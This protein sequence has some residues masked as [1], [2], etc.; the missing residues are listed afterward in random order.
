MPPPLS[1]QRNGVI[2]E[3]LVGQYVKRRRDKLALAL[4]TDGHAYSNNVL[5]SPI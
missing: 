5:T 3:L 2:E 4:L 1:R